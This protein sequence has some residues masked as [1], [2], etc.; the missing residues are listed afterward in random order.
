MKNNET[1][2][3]SRTRRI[4]IGVA[5][6]IVLLAG[7]VAI[8]YPGPGWLIVFAGLTILAQ[9][10][11]WAHRLNV[12]AREQYDRWNDWIRGQHWSIRVLTLLGTALI[13]VLTLWLLNTYG[14]INELFNLGFDWLKSPFVK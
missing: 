12:Y 10:F 9:E 14:L 8:P 13:V 5:G 1:E 2:K 6:G 3:S 11:T 4:I 7:V